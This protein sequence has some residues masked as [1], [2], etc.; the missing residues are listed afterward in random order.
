MRRPDEPTTSVDPLPTLDQLDRL[1]TSFTGTGLEVEWHTTGARRPL[2][3]A[4]SLAAYRIV[5]ESLTNAHRHGRSP[6]AGLRVDYTPDT[7]VVEV[8]NDD[9][10]RPAAAPRGHG[11]I[12]MRERVAA[13]GGTIDVGPTSD[14]RFRVYVTLPLAGGDR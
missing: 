14:G 12:G 8:L 3:P 4:V 5:Q 1:I 13:T 6:R 9:S 2:A 10:D 7:L 11:I